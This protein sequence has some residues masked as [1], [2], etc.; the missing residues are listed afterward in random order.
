MLGQ[1]NNCHL[2]QLSFLK[3]IATTL[4]GSNFN[5]LCIFINIKIVFY[6]I[7]ISIERERA[8][9]GAAE[10]IAPQQININGNLKRDF[11][12]RTAF[13]KTVSTLSL[14]IL[15]QSTSSF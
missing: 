5:F 6:E 7:E 15:N 13:S 4:T 11:F 14:P 2:Y 1:L 8:N 3:V 9:F 12:F 10:I